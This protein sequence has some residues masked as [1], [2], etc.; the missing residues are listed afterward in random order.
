MGAS[1]HVGAAAPVNLSP[2]DEAIRQ[3]TAAVSLAAAID[4]SANAVGVAESE[5]FYMTPEEVDVA[6]DTMESMGVTQVRMFVPWYFVEPAPGVYDWTNVDKVVNAAEERGI[7][8]LG[9]VTSTPTWATDSW[10]P[11]GAPRNPEDFGSFMG[12][13]AERY[14]AGEGDPES[15][16]ISAYEI[17]N[18]PHATPFWQ[19]G[20]D[21]AAYTEVLKAGYEAVKAVDPSGTV[22]GG[23]VYAG[24]SWGDGYNIGAVEFIEGMYD[25]GAAGYF[26]ALSYHPYNND[27][28]FSDGAGSPIS[29]I[30]ILEDIQALMEQN[31]DGDKTVWTSEYGLPTATVSEAQQAE[32][33]DDF[34][35]TWSELDGAGPMFLYNLVDLNTGSTNPEDTYGLFRD[36]W[37]PKQAALAVQAWIE[38]N[39]PLDA[40]EVPAVEDPALPT[41]PE[42]EEPTP[43]T[44]V[45]PVAQ[46][47]A[48]WQ[49]ALDDAAANWA[50]AWG[51]ALNPTPATT[52]VSA[53]TAAEAETATAAETEALTEAESS[54]A[55]TEATVAARTAVAEA[56]ADRTPEGEEPSTATDSALDESTQAVTSAADRRSATP[57]DAEAETDEVDARQTPRTESVANEDGTA[58]ESTEQDSATAEST[59][60]PRT[61][62]AAAEA[63]STS[64]STESEGADSAGGS[65]A[66][67][68]SGGSGS[69]SD[70]SG[71]DGSSSD[72]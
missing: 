36:D 21:P 52:T 4:T 34:M 27:W 67:S 65:R 33:I 13:L 59:A 55:A 9:A 10:S 18:E 58:A 69:E 6:M 72:D 8:V 24:Q 60:T 49:K 50:A 30:G 17:W 57:E 2:Q 22:V 64:D 25:A 71:S 7:A 70:S 48:N 3:V 37:T 54:G 38:E 16:R 56:E 47:I 32:F 41:E 53:L 63:E 42:A 20:P 11:Y 23:V 66:S 51:Q 62:R 44:P 68:E 45:D 1:V 61:E 35:D 43:E 12:A 15:A 40:G 29:G 46:A 14:G 19:P 31:G 39:G 28:R 5:L 26:D